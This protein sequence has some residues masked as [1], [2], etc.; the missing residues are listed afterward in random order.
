MLRLLEI[1]SAVLF[2][3]S[4][5]LLFSEQFRQRRSWVIVASVIA[6]TSSYFTIDQIIQYFY[7]RTI[8]DLVIRHSENS[9][10]SKIDEGVQNTQQ[11]KGPE[12][13][14]RRQREAQAAAEYAARQ[15]REIEMERK[16]LEAEVAKLKADVQRS[17]AKADVEKA[18]RERIEAEQEA[19]RL[20]SAAEDARRE[21]T[22]Q[23]LAAETAA[24]E[25]ANQRRKAEEQ[26]ERQR[27]ELKA[28][29]DAAER[30]EQL[31]RDR[32]F[33]FSVCNH[34]STPISIAIDFF[35][36]ED[37]AR[38][39]EGWKTVESGQC[40]QLGR[41]RRGEFRFFAKERNG[42]KQW[43]GNFPVCVEFPG[44]FKRI[45]AQSYNCPNPQFLKRFNTKFVDTPSWTVNINP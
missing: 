34:T 44:P 42:S 15:Y 25:A 18:T 11:Q 38:V 13:A 32:F 20:Q 6:I 35:S 9:K 43:S 39:V 14:E 37:N 26:A 1:L 29:R 12:D 24:E 2:T 19:K 16:R 41:Y 4:T 17:T 36:E 22:R 10:N 30:Q 7:S 8:I 31:E 21:A 40:P 3:L 28:A 33:V 45:R 5:G 23:R 27:A